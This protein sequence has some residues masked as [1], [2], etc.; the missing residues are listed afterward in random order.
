M[1]K[2][3]SLT[4]VL[5]TVFASLS[6]QDNKNSWLGSGDVFK[7]EPVTDSVL[8]GTGLALNG[9]YLVCDKLLKTKDVPFDGNILDKSTVNAFDQPLMNPY[10]HTLAKTGDAFLITALA[11][12]VL[13]AAAPSN[14][15]FTIT[16]MYAETVLLA[17]GIKDLTKLVVDRPRPSMSFDG[18][19]QKNMEE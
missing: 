19:Q 7:I 8:F 4:L 11:S 18:Y 6:A 13:F 9:T 14:E 3:F 15:W 16:A 1:K 2:F 17:N 5:L 10:N 12:P